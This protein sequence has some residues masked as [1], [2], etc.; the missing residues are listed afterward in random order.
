MLENHQQRAE[1]IKSCI[2]TML[3]RYSELASKLSSSCSS[4]MNGTAAFVSSAFISPRHDQ[5]EQENSH[6]MLRKAEYRNP[7]D[8]L[9]TARPLLGLERVESFRM[10]K[11]V[12]ESLNNRSGLLVWSV[13]ENGVWLDPVFELERSCVQSDLSTLLKERN[14]MWKLN[15]LK[16]LLWSNSPLITVTDSDIKQYGGGIPRY[17]IETAL[18]HMVPGHKW[19][20]VLHI[21]VQILD[22]FRKE[23]EKDPF[24]EISHDLTHRENAVNII[25]TIWRKWDIVGGGPLATGVERAWRNG[26]SV[27]DPAEPIW[28]R[29]GKPLK[30][31]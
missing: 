9:R 18:V 23:K 19:N 22:L 3:T 25:R 13:P 12:I 5:V 6:I 7:V 8:Y 26:S 29:T 28:I 24:P 27:S 20:D 17:S 31:V 2:Q 10:I 4:A 1:D 14:T 30:H 11:Q 15:F 21:M 16:A